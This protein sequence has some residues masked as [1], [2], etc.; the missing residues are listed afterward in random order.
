MKALF[1]K[2]FVFDT[3][4]LNCEISACVFR[5]GPLLSAGTAS[6]FDA[7]D[8]LVQVLRQDVAHLTC[9]A[10]AKGMSTLFAKNGFSR[11]S[12]E[13]FCGV[14]R[15]VLGLRVNARPTENLCSRWTRKTTAALHR[16]KKI[17]LY[18][19]GVDSF[20]SNQQGKSSIILK[21]LAVRISRDIA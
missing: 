18:F 8:V 15:H 5:C 20:L 7:Q 3:K 6:A 16:T 11:P 10:L 21:I 13:L 19:R 9:L 12:L 4:S 14:F 17:G 1:L 2:I